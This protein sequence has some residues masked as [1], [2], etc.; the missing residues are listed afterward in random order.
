EII[1]PVSLARSHD[2]VID[3]ANLRAGLIVFDETE[4]RHG[5]SPLGLKVSAQ[6]ARLMLL[7]Q[8]SVT[9]SGSAAQQLPI[10]TSLTQ[11]VLAV[12]FPA[13]EYLLTTVDLPP[14]LPDEP[15]NDIHQPDQ[16]L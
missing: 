15:Q 1:D 5:G 9:V 8:I 4:N 2:V 7:S 10:Q 16:A 14:P 11:Y 12:I 3:G 13:G 6:T